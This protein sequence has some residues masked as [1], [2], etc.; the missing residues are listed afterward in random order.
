MQGYITRLRYKLVEYQVHVIKPPPNHLTEP[1]MAQRLA[2][3]GSK[4][5]TRIDVKA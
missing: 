2:I 1:K 4:D 5:P 3:L